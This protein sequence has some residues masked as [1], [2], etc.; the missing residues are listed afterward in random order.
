[1]N[2]RLDLINFLIEKHNYRSY[3][4]IGVDYGDVFDNVIAEF[5]IGVD[6]NEQSKANMITTSDDFFLKN[7]Q[8]FDL[9]FI[10]GLHQHEQVYRDIINSLES[11]NVGGTI[12]CHDMWPD[13]D[14]VASHDLV[15]GG[16]WNGDCY[17]A[18]LKLVG[19]HD[20]LLIH[21]LYDFDYGTTVIRKT[22][23]NKFLKR[24]VPEWDVNVETWHNMAKDLGLTM[25]IED[26]V[27]R[28]QEVVICAI[29]KQENNYLEDWCRWHLNLGF[30]RIYI[31]DNNDADSPETYDW[32][33]KKFARVEI[34]NA[35]GEKAQQIAQYKAF[36]NDNIYK[37]V[38][39]I[40]IDEFINT[41]RENYINIKEFLSRFPDT[42]AYIL[43]WRCFHANPDV[44]PIDVPIYE[45]CT[46]PISNNVR[47]DCRPENM[48]GWYK[49]ISRSGLALDMN[50][51]T[52][53]SVT[54]KK[55]NVRD[56]LGNNVSH[57]TFRWRDSNLDTVWINHYII[58]N[59]KDYYYNKYKR[60]H[61]GLDMSSVD[62][63]T[64]WNWNQNI[65]YFTD[66][67]GPLSVEEQKFLLSKGMKPNWTFRPKLSLI[68]HWEPFDI[69][70]YAER[71]KDMISGYILPQ[72][73]VDLT[74]CGDP[75]LNVC[76]SRYGN[77][78]FLCNV[79]YYPSYCSAWMPHVCECETYGQPQIVFNMGYDVSLYNKECNDYEK[80]DILNNSLNSFFAT[81]EFH[82]GLY[83][84]IIESPNKMITMSGAVEH[85]DTCGGHKPL[86]DEFLNEI[87]CENKCLRIKNNT[88]ITSREV[89]ENMRKIWMGFTEKYGYAYNDAILNACR[90]NN[91][92]MYDLWQYIYPCIV[93]DLEII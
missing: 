24:N 83:E 4:E 85:D 88:Y 59:I 9:I 21:V 34:R 40:D 6:P 51:H 29:A 87:G 48:N 80:L 91:M 84:K 28:S 61:A 46:E 79:F 68:C 8:T 26:Y 69:S 89:Y 58:K 16:V 33:E 32:L 55:L 47:K 20:D 62:G 43:Q 3:L 11:L 71:K 75:D 14:Y 37:W 82:R 67:Q 22:D 76:E 93:P 44:T 45:Y 36:C 12:V 64:W 81:P 74:I 27:N 42:D 72:A 23:H 65:N 13:S 53:W 31:Y 38:A 7:R 30:D 78:N 70:W 66:I 18:L 10:D 57:I 2:N 60:G 19:E 86:V 77:M 25:S 17:K 54:G 15:P 50:E 63:Y 39:F 52:I 35:R 92:S 73:D 90:K 56:C 49:T 5:K 41:K 1:M